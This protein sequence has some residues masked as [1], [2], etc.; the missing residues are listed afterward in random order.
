MELGVLRTWPYT[1]RSL[2][3]SF[4]KTSVA[5]LSISVFVAFGVSLYAVSVLITEQGAGGQFSIGL[6]SAAFGGAAVIGGLLA[7]RV[8]RHADDHSVRG[9]AVAGAVLGGI[10]MFVFASANSSIQ[11]I[12]AFWLFLGPA[13]AMTLYEPAF[14]AVSQWVHGDHRN[15][16]IGMLVVIGGLAG[17]V[18]LPLTGLLLDRYEWRTTAVILG[19]LY[20][21]TGVLALIAY[22]NLKP[23][24]DRGQ[25]VPHVSWM[26]FASDRRLLFITVS[27]VLT[28]AAMQSTLLHR[29]A[30]F[31]EHG[32]AV[33]GVAFLAGLSGLMTFPGRYLM[34]RVSD[35]IPPTRAVTFACVGLVG[36]MV[37]AIIGVPWIVMVAF[38]VIFGLFF[39]ILIPTRPVIMNAWYSG[40]DFGA[41]MGKQWAIAAVVGGV[42]PWLVGVGREV[43]GSYTVP[44]LVLTVAIAVAAVF[45]VAAERRSAMV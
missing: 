18:F 39:G 37:L 36:V 23:I 20:L 44:F 13:T 45:N 1:R 15:R 26:R 19:C 2:M 3:H 11:V 27:F 31:E 17:P 9:I 6:L 35:R 32:Y 29:V 43:F 33:T 12:A 34:P 30:L 22:P 10:G 38:F 5:S 7:P 42:T 8:G 21:A 14:V 40:A 4:P 41:V 25:A 16:A 24:D 28:F